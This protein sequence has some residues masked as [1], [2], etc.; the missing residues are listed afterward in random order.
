PL[1]Q[2]TKASF[3]TAVKDLKASFAADSKKH[4]LLCYFGGHGKHGTVTDAK[5]PQRAPL[6]EASTTANGQVLGNGSTLSMRS[7]AD[8]W[9]DLFED[10]ASTGLDRPDIFRRTAPTLT[11][12]TY[13]ES[14]PF[15]S[16]A[17]LT[18]ALVIGAQTIPLASFD[19]AGT[20]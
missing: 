11:L 10:L 5:N 3:E 17:D 9:F 7:S 14:L 6:A 20:P 4:Q 18:V 19:L 2:G 8:L 12:A 15:N 16:V 13:A 1:Q